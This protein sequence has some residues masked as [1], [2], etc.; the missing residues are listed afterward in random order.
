MGKKDSWGRS[1]LSADG[2]ANCWPS[3]GCDQ[4]Y[5]NARGLHSLVMGGHLGV[6]TLL[7]WEDTMSMPEGAVNTSADTSEEQDSSAKKDP[8]GSW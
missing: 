8:C 2:A 7:L 1:E 4:K 3:G 5:P 6:F